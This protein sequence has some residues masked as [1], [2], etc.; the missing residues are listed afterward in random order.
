M[1]DVEHKLKKVI[2][3]GPHIVPLINA[4]TMLSYYG[5]FTEWFQ[6]HR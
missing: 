6:A 4:L 1:L 2:P 3:P 5:I